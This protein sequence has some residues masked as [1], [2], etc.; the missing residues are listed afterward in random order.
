M[1]L[2]EKILQDL[3]TAQK[4][5]DELSLT[6]LRMLKAAL[7]NKHIEKR[8]KLTKDKNESTQD[9][10]KESELSEEEIIKVISSEVKKRKE[11]IE[12]FEKG[13][14]QDLVEKEKKEMEVLQNYLP[15]QLSEEQL[16]KIV[17]ESI[18]E[19]GAADIKDMGRVIKQVM[20]KV[21]V[22]ADGSQVASLVKEYLQK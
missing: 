9:L 19:L 14:R 7:N 16:K 20:D 1:I 3:K 21:G 11:S 4:A 12:S 10:E 22:R 13:K 6:T 17:Q 18:T 15:E 5:R 8:T 2:K